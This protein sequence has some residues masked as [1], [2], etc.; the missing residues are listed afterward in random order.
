MFLFP[1]AYQV[2][3]LR[4]SALL[5][6]HLLVFLSYDHTQIII[7]SL[8]LPCPHRLKLHCW[9]IFRLCTGL[10]RDL[11]DLEKPKRSSSGDIL[12]SS[13][14]T[15]FLA[16][17]DR[18]VLTTERWR[19]RHSHQAF[20]E[21]QRRTTPGDTINMTASILEKSGDN[22]ISSIPSYASIR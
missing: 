6:R 19:Y 20:C 1:H 13:H 22:K 14:R 2:T 15:T 17:S 8:P 12:L 10:R 21:Y 7:R 5:S 18:A 4:S 3:T 11:Q 9:F 16:P